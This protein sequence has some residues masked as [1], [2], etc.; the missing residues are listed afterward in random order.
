MH[1]ISIFISRQAN[2]EENTGVLKRDTITFF[3]VLQDM[4]RWKA[5]LS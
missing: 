5:E 3:T 4:K 1:S 2:T